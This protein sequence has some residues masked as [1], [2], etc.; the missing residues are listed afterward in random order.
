MSIFPALQKKMLGE[1]GLSLRE[2]GFTPKPMEQSF[3]LAKPFG[4]ASIDLAFIRHPAI[5]FDVVVSAAIRIDAVQEMIQERHKLVTDKELKSVATIGCELGNLK[6]IGQQRWTIASEDD[7]SPVASGIVAECEASLLPFI[8]KYSN[9]E[10]LLAVL[11]ADCKE[12]KLISTFDDK[13]KK[14]VVA[15]KELLK[16]S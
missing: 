16:N 12:A 6:G 7:V 13:R 15:L 2:H 1:I 14:I 3:L 11:I 5:D 9:F 10:T 4:W 8:E